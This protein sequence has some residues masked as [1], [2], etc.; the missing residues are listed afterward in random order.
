M[1]QVY[2]VPLN[3]LEQYPWELSEGAYQLKMQADSFITVRT[4]VR[5]WMPQFEPC[6]VKIGDRDGLLQDSRVPGGNCTEVK[7]KADRCLEL[8]RTILELQTILKLKMSLETSAGSL[9]CSKPGDE[10]H[11]PGGKNTDDETIL[12]SVP[13]T[14]T[15]AAEPTNDRP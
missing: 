11:V 14:V 13:M 4:H 2:T 1:E 3:V 8:E 12:P 7:S 15:A 9:L 6:P 10:S 5:R